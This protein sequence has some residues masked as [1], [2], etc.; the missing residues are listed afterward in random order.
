MMKFK[1]IV[2]TDYCNKVADGT[3][4]SPKR[5]DKGKF[6][7]TSRHI[8]GRSIDFENAYLIS[9]QDFNQINQRSKVDQ[10]DILISM[11][12]EY[13]GFSYVERNEIVDYAVKN[14][15]IF[16]TGNKI[17]AEWLY[18]YL[19]SPEGKNTLLTLRGGT[20]Q[21]YIP[22]GALRALEIPV[23]EDETK[24]EQIVSTLSSLDDKIELNLQMNQTLEAMAQAIFKE[25]FV[26]FNFPG[27][28][29][30]W[31]D[32]SPATGGRLPKGWKTGRISDIYKT[33]SGGTPSRAKE[34]FY[35]NGTVKWVKSKE[36]NG[37]FIFDTEEK[38]TEDAIKN[39]SAKKIPRHSILIAMYGA[40]VGEFAVISS[41]ATC[42]QAICAILPNENYPYSY[43]LEY[44]K[45]NKA[46]II[47]Q[48]SGS[49]QQNISQA[50][51]QKQEILIPPSEIVKSFHNV[52]GILFD[53]IENNLFVNQTLTQ[54]RDSLLPK[55]MT[56]KIRLNQD[57]QN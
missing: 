11:I 29:G 6:L 52:V 33:T 38:I 34:E 47:G 49:A 26:N 41:D 43:I 15:G 9:E 56:G 54:I 36:L 28:N 30:E 14:V 50:L 53:K 55:L 5:Q 22:L 48:A 3:H 8:K 45:I 12:G 17:K 1:S 2:A 4:D 51:I 40:T 13:C 31:V 25:W 57:F 10:W 23:P 16:K 18:Y 35:I 19:I 7:I 46:N 39:S 20:S 37:G 32:A 44:I 21:P 24:M 42:N 27:F